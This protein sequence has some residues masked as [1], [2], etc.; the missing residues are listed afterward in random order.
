MVSGW[1]E[2]ALNSCCMS[3]LGV[4][5]LQVGLEARPEIGDSLFARRRWMLMTDGHALELWKESLA[6]CGPESVNVPTVDS[7]MI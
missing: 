6:R 1:T 5:L 2:Q 4:Q 3:L 7:A